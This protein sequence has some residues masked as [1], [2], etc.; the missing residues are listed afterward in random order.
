MSEKTPKKP[1]KGLGRGLSSLL[2]DANAASASSATAS[3][4][5]VA[6]S[7]DVRP[8]EIRV[9]P[10]EWINPGP[11]QPRRVFDKG[12]L[13][14][15]AQSMAENGIIQP[16][17]VRPNP[18]KEGRYQLIAGE[19]RWRAA[20]MA[21]LHDIPTIIREFSDKQAGELSLI[22]NIQRSDL[23]AIEEALG[24]RMLIDTH[25]YT[26]DDLASIVGKSRPHISNMMRLLNLPDEI[27]QFILQ[28][29]MTAG[30]ARPLIGHEDALKIAQIVIEKQ[31]SARDVE[32]LARHEQP[33]ETEAL[34]VEK[35]ADIKALEKKAKDMLGL[36]V[37][38]DWDEGKET[39]AV[40][41]KISNFA[42]LDM[43]LDK[44]G[45]NE[46]S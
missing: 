38:I 23:T 34:K 32:K 31:L 40:K 15:L 45:L 3:L 28:G 46:A 18:Q 39:G 36:R 19:R 25:D 8:N 10:V 20:Q 21:Q 6:S 26:Q 17:L 7:S 44:L 22:E 9:V 16:I 35:S 1:T 42:Q 4:G 2:G 29:K 37:R 30:Q 11:W 5:Q 14:E 43:L 41:V 33:S 27:H 24:Y 13:E 12:A